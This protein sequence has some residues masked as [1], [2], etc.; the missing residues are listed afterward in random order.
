ME[1]ESREDSVRSTRTILHLDLDCF[2]AQVE[3]KRL[4]LPD[5]EPCAVQQ[6]GG[7]LAVN[8]AA[9]PHGV[10]RG[11][12]VEEAKALCPGLHVPHV[13][14]IGGDHSAATSDSPNRAQSKVSLD[15]YRTESSKIFAVLERHAPQLERASIDEG[16]IDATELAEEELARVRGSSA[17]FRRLSGADAGTSGAWLADA[18]DPFDEML[19]AAASVCE[20]L[21]AALRDELGYNASAG[22]AHT[23]MVAKL[24][25]AR[26][27]P[28]RQTVV[29]RA[30]VASLLAEVPLCSVRGLGGKLGEQVA[31]ALPD[32]CTVGALAAVPLCKLERLFGRGTSRWLLDVGTGKLEEEVKPGIAPKSLN[33]LKSFPAFEARD[34]P[35]LRR[36]LTLLATELLERLAADEKQWCRVPKTLKLQWRGRLDTSHLHNWTAGR[37]GELTAMSSRQAALPA[38]RRKPEALVSVALRLLPRGGGGGS[39]SGG[40]PLSLTR[41]GLSCCDFVPLASRSV[42]SML[43]GGGGGG[44]GLEL[45]EM[46]ETAAA[47]TA[48]AETAAV[49]PTAPAA[50]LPAAA[51]PAAP[52]ERRPPAPAAAEG[53]VGSSTSLGSRS[54]HSVGAMGGATTSRGSGSAAGATSRGGGGGGRGK[55]RRS[56]SCS[57][58]DPGPSIAAHFLRL[59]GSGEPSPAVSSAASKSS[60]STKRLRE[61]AQE[62][63]RASAS[64]ACLRCTFLHSTPS[65]RHFLLCELCGLQREAG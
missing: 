15:R 8:Y 55:R 18:D 4:G 36:W 12:R 5:S 61:P 21:R 13:A 53:C 54:T 35:T 56:S 51:S 47:K 45:V 58:S 65:N 26:H 41:L 20:R 37:V 23:K 16:Y 3:S 50:A 10:K 60:A 33:A 14:T 34:E 46:P 2:Y 42:A 6:W 44:S 28:N 1:E 43:G 19:V 7:L 64:W 17:E 49:S 25:S 11:M 9:R 48:A 24:A 29:P 52:S 27:K 59:G 30:A 40:Q 31:A 32:V 63:P 39:G 62:A 38:G 22:I 57:T